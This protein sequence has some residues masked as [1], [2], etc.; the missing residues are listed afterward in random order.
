MKEPKTVVDFLNHSIDIF[1]QR[2]EEYG[3]NYKDAGKVLDI[4]F[5]CGINIC[6]EV[7]MTRFGLFRNCLNKL[8]RYSKNFEKGG[9]EDSITDLRNYSAMLSEIDKENNM[10]IF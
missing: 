7:E 2:D 3:S 5:P 6:G 10:E 9:H 4:L 1:E 8:M